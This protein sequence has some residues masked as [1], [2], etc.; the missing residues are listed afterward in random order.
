MSERN[1]K[2]GYCVR[3][4]CWSTY[5][6]AVVAVSLNML[7]TMNVLAIEFSY[8]NQGRLSRAAYDDGTSISYQYDAAGNLLQ[9]DIAQPPPADGDV[10][11]IGARDGKVTVADALIVL[12][13]ALGLITPIPADDLSHGDVAPLDAQGVPNPDGKLTVADALI[14]LRKA[15]GLVTF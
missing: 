13:Y 1:N 6:K 5:R 14:V 9:R 15:L 10:A 7:L 4:D 11:P 8:D 2:P 12:R 3:A